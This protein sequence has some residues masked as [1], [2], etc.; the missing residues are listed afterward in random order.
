MV[1]TAQS[2]STVIRYIESLGIP[3]SNH[4]D[5]ITLLKTG[6]D[7]FIDL[8]DHVESA[9]NSIHLEY[10]NF[11]NDSI[12]DLLFQKLEARSSDGVKVRAIYDAFGNMSNNRPLRNRH[13][14]A[15]RKRGVEIFKFD[16]IRF[17]YVNHI[18]SRDHRKIVV[19][20]GC[21]GYTG[22]MNVAD[23]YVDG[24][25]NI[26]AWRD[27]HMRIEG[28]SVDRL[29]DIFLNMWNK[30]TG[31]DVSPQACCHR[32]D[33]C[34]DNSLWKLS[35]DIIRGSD[36]LREELGRFL[37]NPV[38]GSRTHLLC[39]VAIVDR[40]PGET[41]SDMR[42][43]YAEAI[44]AAEQSVKIINPYFVPTPIIRRA[45]KKAVRR[46]VDVQIMIPGK[47]DIPFTPKA[48]LYRA[49]QLRKAGAVVY[50]FDG[51]F[52]HTK[53]MMVDDRFCTLGSANL[54][55]RSLRYDRESN[56]FIFDRGV[57]AE[58]TEMFEK[59]KKE[60]RILTREMYTKQSVWKK[61][62]NWV[63]GSMT[64]FL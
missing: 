3:V 26:G 6:H 10:F 61:F 15:I 44:N 4:A 63:A 2:D 16:P 37:I 24:L 53:I 31:Q 21:V 19:I 62:T 17:P 5:N 50:L 25:P 11:R 7:K 58:L 45:I 60:S 12:A 48:A 52:H 49:N 13:M 55:S 1:A 57:T 36:M 46:G 22:G 51:G 34:A 64:P 30:T 23:Y 43:V 33:S 29:Q 42:R 41:P 35:V 40:E 54:D 9:K 14:K 32:S 47:S 56:A 18:F 8:F 39:S 28:P 27:M 20:D 59:D 38:P